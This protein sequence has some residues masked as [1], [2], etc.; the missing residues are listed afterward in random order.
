MFHLCT[1]YHYKHIQYPSRLSIPLYSD[2]HHFACM[3]ATA[4]AVHIGSCDQHALSACMLAK[5]YTAH[6]NLFHPSRFDQHG[7][8]PV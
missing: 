8:R 2:N 3:L 5:A 1:I 7:H 6:I 4:R